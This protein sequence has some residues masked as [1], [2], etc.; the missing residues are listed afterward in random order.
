MGRYPPCSIQRYHSLFISF[1]KTLKAYNR[2]PYILIFSA[3]TALDYLNCSGVI[4]NVFLFHSQKSSAKLLNYIF[5]LSI[6]DLLLQWEICEEDSVPEEVKIS[7]IRHVFKW[8][9]CFIWID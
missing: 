5:I 2:N 8:K 4:I 9:L 7:G 6:K 3:H 1:P